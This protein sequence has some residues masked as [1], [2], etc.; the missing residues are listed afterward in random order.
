MY[1]ILPTQ[2]WDIAVVVR[3]RIRAAGHIR[4]IPCSIVL[5]PL[6]NDGLRSGDDPPDGINQK[7]SLNK[8]KVPRA[9]ATV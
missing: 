5:I 8:T 3:S 7:I 6:C 2:A 4:K 1:N 9:E